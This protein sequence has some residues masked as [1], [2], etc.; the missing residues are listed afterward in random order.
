MHGLTKDFFTSKAIQC[1]NRH[2]Y[3]GLFEPQDSNIRYF[4]CWVNGIIE[5]LKHLPL[6]GTALWLPDDK[7]ISLIDFALPYKWQKHL[8]K[9]G[10]NISTKSLN[11]LVDS[12]KQLETTK[13]TLDNKCDVMNTNNII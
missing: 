7:I 9:Q 12:C 10:F 13:K 6:F 1:R 5:Y 11:K 8:T 4:I 3:W 2:Q